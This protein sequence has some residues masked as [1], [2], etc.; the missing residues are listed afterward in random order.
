LDTINGKQKYVLAG[1]TSYGDGCGDRESPGIYTRVSA[2]LDWI[3][4]N[5][6]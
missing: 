6:D 5:K 4:K 3:K 2:Y 1:I